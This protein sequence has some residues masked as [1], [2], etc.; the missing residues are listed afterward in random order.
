MTRKIGHRVAAGSLF[1][2]L[3]IVSSAAAQTYP[4]PA[5]GTRQQPAPVYGP[6]P[7][8]SR[9]SAQQQPQPQTGVR[10]VA[11]EQPIRQPQAPQ[12]GAV[13]GNAPA[14]M[15]PLNRQVVAE[16]QLPAGFPL[17][18]QL[19]AHVDKILQFWEQRSDQIKTYRCEFK[20]WD[21]DPVFGPKDQP[22][23]FSTGVIQYASPDKGLFHVE[24]ISKSTPAA[25]PGEKAQWIPQDVHGEHWVSD[26]KRVFE[27]DSRNKRVIE[28]HLPPEMQG[29]AIADGPLPFMFGAKAA[30]IKSRYWITAVAPPAGATGE[31]WLEA[32]PKSRSD[33]ANFKWVLVVIDQADYLPKMLQVFSPNFDPK[34]NPAKTA[35]QFD[36]REVNKV[37]LL[38]GLANLNPF[39]REF[40]EPKT[41]AGWKKEIENVPAPAAPQFPPAAGPEQ[42]ARPQPAPALKR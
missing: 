25:K 5:A 26:G 35:Y 20:R 1:T 27:F 2:A 29:R 41:P 4:S 28:R 22:L 38:G 14:A 7:A 34:T 33:A 18:P 13:Q 30:T 10:Q 19:E 42:A 16:P 8:G 21:Y 32:Y 9:A 23:T 17:S 36:K 3:L 31:Y 40:Y 6:A 24:K 39:F 37:D 15:I 11:G 12:R